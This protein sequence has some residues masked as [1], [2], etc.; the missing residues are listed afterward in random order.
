MISYRRTIYQ[1]VVAY[2]LIV[3]TDSNAK[4]SDFKA[5]KNADRRIGWKLLRSKQA[6]AVANEA[7][8][9]ETFRT[10]EADRRA[11]DEN[12][13]KVYFLRSVDDPL[14][15]LDDIIIHSSVAEV[16]DLILSS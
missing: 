7:K 2:C 11:A 14:P 12:L 15:M 13:S 3:E 8:Q 6:A 9:V 1:L 10:M 5:A 4:N 16:F